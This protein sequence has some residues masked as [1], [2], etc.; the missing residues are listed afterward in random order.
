[1]GWDGMGWD[2]FDWAGLAWAGLGCAGYAVDADACHANTHAGVA[3]DFTSCPPAASVSVFPVACAHSSRI[4]SQV[5]SERDA[6]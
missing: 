4:L 6:L 5:E 3:L 2:W 1:M